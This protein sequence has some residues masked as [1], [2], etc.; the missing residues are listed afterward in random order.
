MAFMENFLVHLT[1]RLCLFLEVLGVFSASWFLAD[2]LKRIMRLRLD[3]EYLGSMG[4]R[5][6]EEAHVK[7]NPHHH[8]LFAEE[9]LLEDTY[10]S[11]KE[12]GATRTDAPEIKQLLSHDQYTD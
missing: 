12:Y 11:H 7:P 8:N 10:L 1:I 4:Q 3:T 6:R 9:E 5:E 2:I